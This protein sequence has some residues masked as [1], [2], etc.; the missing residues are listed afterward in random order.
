MSYITDSFK[1]RRR[2]NAMAKRNAEIHPFQQPIVDLI[3]HL[4]AWVEAKE[5]PAQ[6]VIIN[7]DALH[8]EDDDRT[9]EDMIVECKHL[10]DS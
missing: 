5:H 1:E 7:C 9:I 10:L 2:T 6:Q 3:N 8:P 4:Y